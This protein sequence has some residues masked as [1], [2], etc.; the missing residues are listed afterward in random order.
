M[1]KNWREQSIS[2]IVTTFPLSSEVF[3]SAGI[4]Y[5]CGGQRLLGDVIEE[6]GIVETNLYRALDEMAQH[7][8]PARSE[9]F[10]EMKPEE[11]VEHILI[12]HHAYLWEMLPEI[13]GRLITVLR[14]HG[15]RHPELYDVYKLLNE[16]TRDME[17][18]LIR[19]ESEL[20]P[21]VLNNET[22]ATQERRTLVR[23]LEDEHDTTTEVLKQLRHATNDYSV[24]SDACDNFAELYK[25]LE[26][27]EK[28]TKEHYHLEDDILFKKITAEE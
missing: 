9:S 10:P 11:L 3:R 6:E 21:S 8:E 20:F 13:H 12:K 28:D 26:D 27:L 25:E 24:P 1:E 2:E 7:S 15:D 17:P 23:I 18:H 4:D 16:L 14:A 19:E 5:C 22:N